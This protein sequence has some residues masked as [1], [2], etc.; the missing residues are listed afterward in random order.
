MAKAKTATST[1]SNSL[2]MIGEIV[3]YW[4]PKIAVDEPGKTGPNPAVVVRHDTPESGGGVTLHVFVP[5]NPGIYPVRNIH[6]ESEVEE[7]MPFWEWPTNA[8]LEQNI[9]RA[10]EMNLNAP[11]VSVADDGPRRPTEQEKA[12]A[13][14]RLPNGD[15]KVPVDPTRLARSDKP[16]TLD[17]MKYEKIASVPMGTGDAPV[18]QRMMEK[19]AHNRLGAARRLD[20]RVNANA[21][22]ANRTGRAMKNSRTDLEL[23]TGAAKV[24][25]NKTASTV[26]DLHGSAGA[27]NK[28]EALAT[29]NARAFRSTTDHANL[30]DP[31]QTPHT[32]PER[33]AKKAAELK[34][35]STRATK[36]APKVKQR[37][38]ARR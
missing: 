32:A 7:G 33:K 19:A 9:D 29:A 16:G 12:D 31:D 10:A 18:R 27:T 34:A 15:P 17:E 30:A 8:T 20:E 5:G 3:H 4:E 28:E 2:P 37:S 14:L 26:A 11:K 22:M 13:K 24:E 6:Q 36:H 38:R 25:E 21:N 23:A 1:P 35:A